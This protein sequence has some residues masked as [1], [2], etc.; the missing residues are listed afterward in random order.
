VLDLEARKLLATIP[1]A[2]VIQRISLSVDDRWV[3][4]A[5]QTK[6]RLVVIDTST[7]SV[8]GSI[9]LPGLA[10][11]TAP[12]PDGRWLLVAL[13]GIDKVG[14]VDLG[15]MRMVRTLDVPKAPQEILLPPGGGVAYVSCDSS[16][17]VAAIDLKEWKVARLIDV[18]ALADGLAWVSRN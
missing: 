10:F 15:T 7:N 17:Q 6:L 14:L 8:S 2:T 4:T 12:T 11:G 5:D 1:V 16:R 3:F 13:P 9:A 18:G